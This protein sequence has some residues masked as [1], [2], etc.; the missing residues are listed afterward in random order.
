MLYRLQHWC[1][2]LSIYHM[3]ILVKHHMLI[4]IFSIYKMVQLIVE[5]LDLLEIPKLHQMPIE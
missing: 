1:L 2:P 3:L 4:L 5:L